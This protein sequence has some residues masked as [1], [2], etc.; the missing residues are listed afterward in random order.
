M[1]PKTDKTETPKPVRSS[2]LVRRRRWKFWPK[3]TIINYHK[4][5]PKHMRGGMWEKWF[6]FER[7]WGGRIWYFGVR[8]LAIELDFRRDWLYDM[9]HPGV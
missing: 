7:M 8:H 3:A 5:F 6:Y 9:A 2:E 1:T 4:N